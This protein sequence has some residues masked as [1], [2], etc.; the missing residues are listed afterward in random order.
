MAENIN[1]MKR[2]NGETDFV[3]MVTEPSSYALYGSHALT[4][5]KRHLDKGE[6][7]EEGWTMWY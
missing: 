5:I 6:T 2:E 7:P 1:A 3:E 4:E